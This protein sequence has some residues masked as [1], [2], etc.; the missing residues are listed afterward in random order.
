[1]HRSEKLLKMFLDP[2][3]LYTARESRTSLRDA[4][5]YGPIISMSKQILLILV[6]F[7]GETFTLTSAPCKEFSSAIH[8]YKLY[9][10]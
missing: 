4:A 5:A 3:F 2:I 1:M 7:V 8:T 10:D 9:S 6:D